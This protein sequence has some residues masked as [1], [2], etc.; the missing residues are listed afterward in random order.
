M[1]KM[2]DFPKIFLLTLL[3][4]ISLIGSAYAAPVQGDLS[5]NGI[6]GLEDL[7]LLCDYWLDAG[8]VA[9]GC[10]ADL[11]GAAG[12]N[13][14]DF[15]LLARNFGKVRV[16]DR[17]DYADR[18]RALWLGECIANWTG[19]QTEGDRSSP[20]FY[21]DSD[22]GPGGFDFILDQDPWWAD[23][24]TDIEYVY[25]H[26][27]DQHQ[28]NMLSGQQI[29]DGW[30]SH[31]NSYIWVSDA[32]AR[33]LMDSGYT[34]PQTGMLA[35]NDLALMIDAQLTT[36]IFGVYA[37]G[38]A[39][40]AMEMA[41]LPIRL[42]ATGY[43]AHAAQ[44][45][46]L[47]Y[48]LASDVDTSLSRKDQVLWLA[49]EARKYI[50]DTSKSA[51]IYDFVKADYL[52]NSNKDDWESTRDKIYDRYQLNAA[53]NGFRYQTWYESSVNFAAGI[54]ALLYG[55][56]D[57][58]KTVKIG[59]LSGWDS[60]N[61]TA[62][63]GGL[64]GFM[65]GYS[66][67][68]AEFVGTSFSDRYW[69]NRTRDNMPDYLPSD[70]DAE[71][72]FTMLANRMLDTID[73]AIEDAGGTVDA[74]SNE[75]LLP[76]TSSATAL[77][78]NP[79]YI[80]MQ[81]S[82]N[83][84]VR[85][86]GGTVTPEANVPVSS[87]I[88]KMADGF[89]HNF[90]G[91]EWWPS[92]DPWYYSTERGG[93]H[94]GEIQTLSVTYDRQ[95][96]VS[97]IRYIEGASAVGGGWFTSA[98]V[99]VEVNS[100]WQAPPGTVTASE[101]LNSSQDYQIIDYIL[102]TPVRATGIRITGP[103]GGTKGYVTALELDAMSAPPTGSAPYVSITSPFN[104]A[105]FDEG[106]TITIEVYAADADGSV[107]LVEFFDG[108]VKLGEDS[109]EPY[110]Y[111]WV[112]ASLGAHSLKAKATDN[113]SK[114]TT[115]ATVN[116][117]VNPAGVAGL[118]RSF[119]VVMNPSGSPQA[120]ATDGNAVT[121]NLEFYESTNN[122]GV[123]KGSLFG[124]Y[125]DGSHT[126]GFNHAEHLWGDTSGDPYP[127]AAKST[128][129]RGSD[130]GE[131]N[132]PAPSGVF[133]LQLHP[134]ENDHLVVAAFIVPVAG[135][136]SVYDLAVRRVWWEGSLAGYRVFDESKS[137]LTH[138]VA[139]TDQDW[140]TDPTTYNLGTLLAG[141]RIYFAVDRE[142]ANY[143]WDATEIIWTIQKN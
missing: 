38:M 39:D 121:A 108:A 103:V 20:P 7:K 6:V 48:S 132:T 86:L 84:R 80:E 113:D 83:N 8:C 125:T 46:M 130:S 52:A 82:A 9:P 118:W 115:S 55:E 59:T 24:D 77:E 97:I 87:Y 57:Y 2:F 128:V 30:M 64:L 4:V 117:S 12:V 45:F 112:G 81:Q 135:D 60:D 140:V 91:D 35:L 44:Y 58:K 14:D 43:A 109:N 131:G 141:D 49:D 107:T 116:I 85:D 114:T 110:S 16:I 54:I 36:E 66:D 33:S 88:E 75:W 50:P 27:M 94:S 15:E 93:N 106:N 96:D 67:L 123:N 76:V 26:L 22:W 95:V 47:L 19:I 11:G 100:V 127:Y 89:E 37:P 78:Q 13:M 51:D 72:T 29:R 98:D 63:L 104:G 124:T 25:C 34:T 73:I 122:D 74:D 53:S 92:G 69:I 31:I 3:F 28:T 41:N 71:D 5:A 90:E 136:Y 42:V 105:T 79:L 68:V 102:S 99:E 70:S 32:Q 133:D 62:T 10:E 143:Y 56:G 21:D 134:P 17:A 119:D 139:T 18:L 61:S 120:T 101:P 126:E 40:M 111:D 129:A 138:I 137:L 23:D 1:M 65:Y 142:D